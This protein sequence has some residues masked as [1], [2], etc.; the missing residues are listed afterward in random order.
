MDGVVILGAEI[1]L[2]EKKPEISKAT[3]D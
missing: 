2:A 3:I 1:N